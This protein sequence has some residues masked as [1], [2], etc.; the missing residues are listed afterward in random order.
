MVGRDVTM[1]TILR[2]NHIEVPE[3]QKNSP[4]AQFAAKLTRAAM[5][6]IIRGLELKS[7]ALHDPPCRRRGPRSEHRQCA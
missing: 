4:A 6:G 1:K 2:E 5:N 7:M 3:S